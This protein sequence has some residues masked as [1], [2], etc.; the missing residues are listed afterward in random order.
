MKGIQHQYG[1]C[2]TD[3]CVYCITKMVPWSDICLLLSKKEKPYQFLSLYIGPGQLVSFPF[4]HHKRTIRT[5]RGIFEVTRDMHLLYFDFVTPAL[6]LI[7][8]IGRNAS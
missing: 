2:P 4:E 8:V 1:V 6:G 5:V 7:Q 3:S